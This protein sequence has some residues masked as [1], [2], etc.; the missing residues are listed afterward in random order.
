MQSFCHFPA[1]DKEANA[2]LYY[3]AHDGHGYTK[4]F[5]YVAD[6]YSGTDSA[7]SPRSSMSVQHSPPNTC[8]PDAAG[9]IDT[10]FDLQY[11]I[12]I[13]VHPGDWWDSSQIYREYFL[14]I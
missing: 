11:N 5:Q 1:T 6:Q 4:T 7:H 12:V 10:T 9:Q 8:V 13:G 3:G 14:C 2:C